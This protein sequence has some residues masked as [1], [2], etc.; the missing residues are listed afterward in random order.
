MKIR[1]K[2]RNKIYLGILVLIVLG[3]LYSTGYFKFS[4]LGSHPCCR[5]GYSY[6]ESYAKHI[7]YSHVVN[8]VIDVHVQSVCRS[9]GCVGNT[10]CIVI[11]DIPDKIF[12][13]DKLITS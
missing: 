5:W 4:I 7:P 2:D 6:M 9:P 10:G 1:K 11:Y 8:D 13:K 3:V 12:N